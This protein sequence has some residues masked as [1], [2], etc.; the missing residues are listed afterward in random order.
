MD[1]DGSH[2]RCFWL[3]S[4]PEERQGARADL[5]ATRDDEAEP[6]DSDRQPT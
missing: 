6:E 5:G 2:A 1:G 4:R 3:V